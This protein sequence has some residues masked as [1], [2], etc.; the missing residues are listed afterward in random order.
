VEALLLKVGEAKLVRKLKMIKLLCS[1][2]NILT[3]QNIGQI[4]IFPITMMVLALAKVYLLFMVKNLM[5]IIKACVEKSQ[6]FG[7]FNLK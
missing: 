1:I 4:K 6:V 7:D 3:F 2:L 5:L